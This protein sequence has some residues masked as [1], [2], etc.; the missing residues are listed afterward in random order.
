MNEKK[1]EKNTIGEN[2]TDGDAYFSC[3]VELANKSISGKWKILILYRL[4]LS[5]V[6]RYTELRKEVG[7]IS[8]KMLASQLRDLENDGLVQ[9]TVYP[10]VPPKVE[11]SLTESGKGIIPVIIA[12]RNFGCFLKHRS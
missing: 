1:L 3:H 11:Y 8:E 2:Y 6:I 5:P 10:V 7:T 4:S 9:R 12:L